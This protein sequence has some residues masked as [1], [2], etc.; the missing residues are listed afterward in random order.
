M[1]IEAINMNFAVKA[2]IVADSGCALSL[3]GLLNY[4]E[5]G[6]RL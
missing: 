1:L 5:L 6:Q 4:R 2:D 3:V